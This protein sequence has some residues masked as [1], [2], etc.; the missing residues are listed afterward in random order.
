MA[1]HHIL[2]WEKTDSCGGTKWYNKTG[3]GKR[4]DFAGD[5]AP[6]K[7]QF[8]ERLVVESHVQ[9]IN[10]LDWYIKL[11]T[12]LVSVLDELGIGKVELGKQFYKLHLLRD[13]TTN[14][15]ICI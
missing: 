8:E 1:H 11:V 5:L 13:V 4:M 9:L 14:K 7:V 2:Q 12:H 10:Y 3:Q 15:Y 6:L